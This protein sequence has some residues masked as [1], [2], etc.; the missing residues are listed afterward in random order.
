MNKV[1]I[2]DY[3]AGNVKSIGNMLNFLGIDYEITSNSS[4]I[5]SSDRIIFPGQGHFEQ[6]MTKLKSKNLIEPIKTAIS[7]GIPF[8]GICLG[9]QVLFLILGIV[10]FLFLAS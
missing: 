1:V 9:L 3:E 10:L 5:L 4:K 8:L 6:A 7:K 2:I